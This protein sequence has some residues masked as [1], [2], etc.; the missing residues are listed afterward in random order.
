MIV[1]ETFYRREATGSEARTLPAE[2]YNLAHT[3]LSRAP[4][5]CLFVPIRSM[6]YLAVLDP[7]E[8]IFVDREGGRFIE[9]A[10]RRFRPQ[11]RASLDE[12]VSYEAVY[13]SPRAAV[14]MT[15][16]QCEFPKAL[17]DLESRQVASPAGRV[18]RIE[19]H[20]G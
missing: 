17:R 9:V 2:T 18:I 5:G 20:R 14:P 8:F 6:Q 16:L 12:P 19:E 11:E 1:D 13:Y 15:R 3:L 4:H 7:Q 10:W